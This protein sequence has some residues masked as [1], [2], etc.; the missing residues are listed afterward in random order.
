MFSLNQFKD[1]LA[2]YESHIRITLVLGFFWIE[3]YI[4][5]YLFSRFMNALQNKTCFGEQRHCLS[6]LKHF[7]HKPSSHPFLSNSYISHP[8]RRTRL[9]FDLHHLPGVEGGGLVGVGTG[10]GG[11]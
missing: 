8:S 3:N 9:G 7:Y 5:F 6:A 4:S 10:F 2:R 1:I 11:K